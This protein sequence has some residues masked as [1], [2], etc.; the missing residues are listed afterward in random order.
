VRHIGLCEVNAATLRRAHAVHPITAVQSEY[1]LW[2]RGVED[3]IRPAMRDLGVGFVAFSPLGRGF[4]TGAAP[5]TAKLT[6]GDIRFGD[7]RYAP[8]NHAA[9][10]HIV[11][12]LKA[13]AARQ[14]VS[15]AQVALAWLMTRGEDVIA[16][17]GAKRRVTME[18]SM[19]SVTLELSSEDIAELELA[20]P[21]GGTIGDRYSPAA[22]KLVRV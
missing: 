3:D 9:N 14:G 21:V 2:E 1:S 13:V 7:L 5:S 17:P 11:D 10:M 18:D 15:A 16:I 20:A 12:T 4:L 19:A 8:E 22:M 6:S